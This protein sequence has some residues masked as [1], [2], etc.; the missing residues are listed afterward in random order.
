[1]NFKIGQKVVA[2]NSSADYRAQP[3]VKGNIYTVLDIL[4]CSKCGIQTINI[5][6]YYTPPNGVIWSGNVRCRC[7]SVQP[8]QNKPWTASSFF[9]PLDNLEAT[10]AEL[11]E[12]EEYE[13]CAML[14]K[15]LD[16]QTVTL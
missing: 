6:A 15:I 7:G 11:A 16:E 3:R 4:Y 1:M 2:L 9:A 10:I 12:K 8:H 14:Q 5:T 13:T